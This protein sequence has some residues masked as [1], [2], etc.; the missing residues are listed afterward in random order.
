MYSGTVVLGKV[1]GL[2]YI[3]VFQVVWGKRGFEDT[4]SRDLEEIECQNTTVTR[5]DSKRTS[6]RRALAC[7]LRLVRGIM[8]L[9]A[10]R[11]RGTAA[12]WPEGA[13]ARERRRLGESPLVTTMGGVERGALSVSFTQTFIHQRE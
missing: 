5:P 1:H 3:L 2:S 8:T 11:R 12:A 4:L 6:S 10:L 7:G 13:A 9:C